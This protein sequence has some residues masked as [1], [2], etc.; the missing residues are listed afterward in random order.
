[1]NI[2]LS[3]IKW[4]PVNPQEHFRT[5][6]GRKVWIYWNDKICINGRIER[7][8]ASLSWDILSWDITGS[9]YYGFVESNFDIVPYVSETVEW[10]FYKNTKLSMGFFKGIFTVHNMDNVMIGMGNSPLQAIISAMAKERGDK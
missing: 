9:Y 2:D 4:D 1:M 6:D 3:K 10:A 8:N 7:C 5:R